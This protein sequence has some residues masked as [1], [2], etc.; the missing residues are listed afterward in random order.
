MSRCITTPKLKNTQAKDPVQPAEELR[1]GRRLSSVRASR[2]P[3]AA[4][5]CRPESARPV[6][7]GRDPRPGTGTAGEAS[8]PGDRRHPPA[9]QPR[10]GRNNRGTLGRLSR[11]APIDEGR[12]YLRERGKLDRHGQRGS[13]PPVVRRQPRPAC[14]PL[15]GGRDLDENRQRPDGCRPKPRSGTSATPPAR[16]APCAR[17]PPASLRAK[18]R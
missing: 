13:A 16:R 12:L 11:R 10:P 15:R 7:D 1:Y 2:R 4:R 18:T 3:R 6:R 14:P 17:P 5:P 9:P 8:A